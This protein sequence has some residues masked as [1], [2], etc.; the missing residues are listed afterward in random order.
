MVEKVQLSEDFSA[1]SGGG[2]VVESVLEDLEVK[3][4]EIPK[5]KGVV[6]PEALIGN[7]TPAPR[8]TEV[9]RGAHHPER[10]L[11]IHWAEPAH[12]IRFME[13]TYGDQ[14]SAKCAERIIKLAER[15][16]KE[17]TLVRRDVRGFITCRTFYAML[18]E[19]F[20]LVEA[21]YATPT[22]VDRSVRNDYGYWITFA[23][24]F[25]YMDLTGIPVDMAVMREVVESGVRGVANAKGFDKNTPAEPDAGKRNS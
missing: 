12:I 6:S 5:M 7:N 17:P 25:R 23:G 11:G 19:A 8:V 1:L 16:K 15:W 24:L 14:T 3:H 20:H 2:I 13:V 18:R 21:G 9:E 10:I 4:E 22:D